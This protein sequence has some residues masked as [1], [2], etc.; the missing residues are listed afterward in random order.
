MEAFVTSNGSK[1][2]KI[3]ILLM[4][5][6]VVCITHIYIERRTRMQDDARRLIDIDEVTFSLPRDSTSCRSREIV[7]QSSSAV[8]DRNRPSYTR[9]LVPSEKLTYT[10]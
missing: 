6:V 4:T 8:G 3:I 7:F 9:W 2:E 1:L 5:L 10:K